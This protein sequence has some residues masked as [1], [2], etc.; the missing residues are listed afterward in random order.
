LEREKALSLMVNLARRLGATDVVASLETGSTKM[1]RF[2]N[3][4]V[5]VSKIFSVSS[6][7]VYVS[8][9]ERRAS[10]TTTEL[11]AGS[12]REIVQRAVSEAKNSLPSDVYAPLPKGPF[13]YDRSLLRGS[14]IRASPEDLVDYV[15]A[16][17]RGA[18]DAGADRAAGT[19]V[20]EVGKTAVK[21][22]AGVEAEASESG[23]KISTR[24][25]AADDATGHFVSVAGDAGLFKPYEAGYRAGEMAKMALNPS[26][27]EPGEYEALMGPMTFAH[28]VEQVGDNS[29]AFEVD[30]GISFLTDKLNSRVASEVFTLIDDPTDAS[31]YGSKAFDDEGVRTQRNIIVEDGV[32]KTYLHNT[33]TAKKFGTQTTA[34]AGLIA[35]H[36]FNLKV[37]VGS[38]GVEDLISGIDRGIYVTNDWYLRYQNHRTGDFSTIPRDAMFLI[39]RGSIERPIKGLRLSDN[40]LRMFGKLREVGAEGSWIEWWEVETPTYAPPAVFDSVNFT[41]SAL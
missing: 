12:L 2:A 13:K 40:I 27:Q 39:V 16:S 17:I 32:L 4:E 37:R 31:S 15:E 19:L 29:S 20:Y 18:L 30:S 36:P 11:S 14:R 34:N 9:R 23:L 6:A 3:N 41:A 7:S 28:L 38:K 22:S 8:I 21:T 1:L 25:F 33:T 26:E 24:A 35:P 10:S 5:T